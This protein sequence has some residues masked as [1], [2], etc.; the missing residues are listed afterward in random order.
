MK[1]CWWWLQRATS[2]RSDL[3]W[4]GPAGVL[5]NCLR[6]AM[7]CELLAS[8]GTVY[9]SGADLGLRAHPTSVDSSE[10]GCWEDKSSCLPWYG[11]MHMRTYTEM[12]EVS[13]VSWIYWGIL[14]YCQW[15]A[16]RKCGWR[17]LCHKQW[18]LS[19]RRYLHVGNAAVGVGDVALN[20]KWVPSTAPLI[21]DPW[22]WPWETSI[23]Q[24]AW[25]GFSW[26]E[27]GAVWHSPPG[28]VILLFLPSLGNHIFNF[29]Q[30]FKLSTVELLYSSP[31]NRESKKGHE[32]LS[33]LCGEKGDKWYW[34]TLVSWAAVSS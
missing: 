10:D 7:D 34:S 18:F 31:E 5:W 28:K 3:T 27:V 33:R 2:D 6:M 4:S 23:L 8:A 9:V 19:G 25:H 30:T 29:S 24:G 32:V 26:M 14:V 15:T 16:C 11:L 20:E 1:L 12:E 22:W 13:V 17:G 21:S